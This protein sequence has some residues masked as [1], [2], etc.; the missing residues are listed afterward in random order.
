MT[1][2]NRSRPLV[3]YLAAG[4]LLPAGI[5]AYLLHYTTELRNQGFDTRIVVFQPLPEVEHRFLKALRDRGIPIL[6]LYH[7][8]R[9]HVRLTL[10]LTLVPWS[11]SRGL[12]R[13]Q[14]SGWLDLRTHLRKKYAVARLRKLLKQDR[15]DVVHVKGR[16]IVEAFAALPVERTLYQHTLMGTVDPSWTPPEVKDFRSFLNRIAR[17]F[18]Q[19]SSI[20]ETMTREF[21][22]ERPIEV[23]PTMVPDE[24]GEPSDNSDSRGGDVPQFGIVC[25][26]TEQKG[27]RYILD[28][29]VAFRERHGVARFLF[30]GMGPLEDYIREFASGHGLEHVIVRGVE[31]PVAVLRE[32]DVFVHPGLDDAMPVSIV[33]ALMCG[34]PCIASTVGATP[35]LVRGGIEGYLI[36]PA[37]SNAILQA[38][39][40]CA[41]WSTEERREFRRRARGRYVD[42]CLPSTVGKTVARYYREIMAGSAS[43]NH[44]PG[45]QDDG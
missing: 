15:P 40:K 10:A 45:D 32:L 28:A 13:T 26:F 41:A 27:I 5:E 7:A 24:C 17:I 3:W 30:A 16:I 20:A 14:K 18:V 33:E 44:S 6:S 21:G 1:G 22:I 12:S 36:P 34:V 37:D 35:E 29:L 11:V 38:M 39:E 43:L 8:C 31:D 9:W 23:I 2:K 42:V 25:R 19:G 4:Y